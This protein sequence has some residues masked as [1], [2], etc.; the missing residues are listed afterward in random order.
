M[1]LRA[2]VVAVVVTI[3][4]FVVV[5]ARAAT[6]PSPRLPRAAVDF[7]KRNIAVDVASNEPGWREETA[8]NFPED[9]WSQSDDFHAKEAKHVRALADK[10]GIRIEDALR[11]IDDDLHARQAT[12]ASPDPRGAHAVPC[13][14]RPF[15]D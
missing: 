11:A 1:D 10:M 5:I 14:P 13:K 15:Y 3:V 9:A 4:C 7:E 6:A 12:A 2:S 8:Q